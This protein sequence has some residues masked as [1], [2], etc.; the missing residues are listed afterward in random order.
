MKIIINCKLP[1]NYKGM[2]FDGFYLN[3]TFEQII[4]YYELKIYDSNHAIDQ[5][6]KRFPNLTLQDYKKVFLKG[7]EKIVRKW[8]YSTNQYMIISKST[9]I[10]I[11]LHIRP[12]LQRKDSIVGVT[13][14][15]LSAKDHPHNTH[16]EIEVLVESS[17]KNKSFK[18][19]SEFENVLTKND[20][21]YHWFNHYFENGS[22]YKDFEYIEVE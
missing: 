2:Y 9:D 6:K 22:Y 3:E 10:K 4:N 20:Y 18:K 13:A 21:D 12:D 11:Q 1:E 15:T 16:N 14:S 19:I 5:F 8:D 7:L 17:R